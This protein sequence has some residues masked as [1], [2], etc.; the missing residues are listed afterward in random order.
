MALLTQDRPA[1]LRLEG[2]LIVLAAIVADDLETRRSVV[3]GG[4]FLR[5]ALQA[6]LRGCE[7]SLIEGF[8]FF[9][10]EK[11]CLFTL[12]TRSFYIGHRFLTS[13][14]FADVEHHTTQTIQPTWQRVF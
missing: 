3:S 5:S 2:Y 7:I 12:H 11:K 9:F 6:A 10:S 13:V 1:D 14:H 8:L 4:H